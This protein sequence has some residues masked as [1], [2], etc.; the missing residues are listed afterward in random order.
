MQRLLLILLLGLN[1]L[2][3][4]AQLDTDV[5]L[6]RVF[7]RDSSGW[8][9]ETARNLTPTQGYHNQP[10]FTLD[11]RGLLFVSRSA[12][13]QEATDVYRFDLGKET[14][15]R[16]TDTP[17]RSEYSPTPAPTGK[18]YSAVVVEEDSTQRLW[19]F[20]YDDAQGEVLLDELAD[21]GYHAWY[22]RKHLGLFVVRRPL[23]LQVTHVKRQQPH[24]LTDSIGRCL[25]A[26]PGKRRLSYVDKS[27]DPWLINVWDA[28]SGQ[29]DTVAATLPACE[30]YAW[31]PEGHLLMAQGSH[32]YRFRPGQD[33]T[34]QDL[35][36]LGVGKFYRLAISP[37]GRWLAVV[38]YQ[39]PKP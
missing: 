32:L 35:G 13:P 24:L 14:M 31:T 27:G 17:T 30:D 7:S 20:A 22:H 3:L 10:A 34:W 15:Q 4:W 8:Q 38:T 18:G 37:D 9:L 28:R 23:S 39:G 12:D 6:I 36:D 25:A 21:I 19:Y 5:Y 2:P 1:G 29:T 16:L 33:D 26:A 11:S